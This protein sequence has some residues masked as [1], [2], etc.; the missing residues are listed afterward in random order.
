MP[1]YSFYDPETG[2][3]TGHS[4]IGD[5][6]W[7]AANTPPGVRAIESPR[8]LDPEVDRI[9]PDGTIY[10]VK[11]ARPPDTPLDTYTF[12]EDLWRWVAHPTVERARR[13]KLATIKAQMQ[14][15]EQ[16]PIEVGAVRY[17][18]DNASR[19]AMKDLV[20][21]LAEGESLPPTFAGWRDAD[22]VMR[23]ADKEAGWVEDA[24]SS[25]L[26]AIEE[27]KQALYAWVWQVQAE[28]AECVSE[29]AV[30]AYNP[31]AAP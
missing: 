26:L 5:Q 27:R 21:Y 11:P 3:P 31:P 13:R 14:Y 29:E 18:A 30:L 15:L 1:N 8:E 24:L 10:R 9:R 6:R 20:A 16:L 19:A 12:D 17:D 23:F 28:L 25:V 7:L 22:N 4:F 2:V